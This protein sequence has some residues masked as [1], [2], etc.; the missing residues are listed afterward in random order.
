MAGP[1]QYFAMILQGETGHLPLGHGHFWER[2]LS[3]RQLLGQAVGLAGLAAGA[4]LGLPAVASAAKSSSGE[5]KA[6]P[7]GTTIDGLGLFH[8]Y[9]P[10]LNNPA[11][12]TD[13]VANGRGDP[14][15]I[16]DFNGFVGVGEWG[17]GTGTDQ[18]G[19]TLYWAAD[20]RFIDGEYVDVNGRHQQG[21]FA[22]V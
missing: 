21:A 16:F 3:R 7:G 9:F 20:L 15:T 22:F 10:T 14:S 6:I 18:N 12:A 8:L 11:G 1:E 17:G 4:S 5:P 2:A 19:N 13:V